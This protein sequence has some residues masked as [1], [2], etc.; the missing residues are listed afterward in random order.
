[1]ITV[2]QKEYL[3]PAACQT[4][5]RA[6]RV[7]LD[8]YNNPL[9]MDVDIKSDN[10]PIT[11]A[12]RRAHELIKQQLGRTRIPVLSEE[13]REMLYAE[14]KGWDLFWMVDPLDGTKEFIKG[15]GEF[16]V[17]IALMVDNK[18]CFGVVYVPYIG[19]LYFNDPERGAFLLDGV[20]ADIEAEM[21]YERLFEGARSLPLTAERNSPIRIAMSRSHNTPETFARIESLRRLFPDAE[22]VEQ[23]SSYKLCLIAEGTC[24]YYVR[25]THTS[26][27]DTA[28]GE[29]LLSSAGGTLLSHPEGAVLEYNKESLSNPFFECRSKYFPR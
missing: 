1:M 15:N 22:V 10:T 29:A 18:P 13:G 19:K 2:Q 24:D 14:R 26:E 17:N 3:L 23:G 25:T 20:E 12:D 21:S 28:A 7:I 6:G 27:W 5:V 11:R 4:A 16:T 8:I 9:E